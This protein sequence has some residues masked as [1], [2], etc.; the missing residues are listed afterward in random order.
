MTSERK[1]PK[2]SKKSVL[3][4]LAA[5]VALLAYCSAEIVSFGRAYSETREPANVFEEMY[6]SSID[7]NSWAAVSLQG[8]PIWLISSQGTPIFPYKY[9]PAALNPSKEDQMRQAG[10]AWTPRRATPG[11]MYHGA[12]DCDSDDTPEEF[13]RRFS[14]YYG[15][16]VYSVDWEYELASGEKVYVKGIEFLDRGTTSLAFDCNCEISFFVTTEKDARVEY[17]MTWRHSQIGPNFKFCVCKVELAYDSAERS[18]SPVLYMK[19][20]YD[21]EELRYMES[22]YDSEELRAIA[23]KATAS[24]LG[25]YLSAA[26]SRFSQDDLGSL[27]WL[28]WETIG[29]A[30]NK[31]DA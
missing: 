1:M 22:D 20:D 29:V 5:I 12:F 6:W 7:A 16:W 25:D 10:F 21:S 31:T 11:V 3:I 9:L 19:S 2:I 27:N 28:D 14:D 30:R 4:W 26:D 13:E 23:E 17:D 8:G 15:S 18:L 24:F